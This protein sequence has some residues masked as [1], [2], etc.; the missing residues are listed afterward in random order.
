MDISA[1]YTCFAACGEVTTDSRRCPAGSLFIA[2]RGASF[3]G[4]D[5]AIRALE[6]GCRYAVVDRDVPCEDTAMQAR[7]LRVDDSLKALQMLARE[8]RRR[9][10]TR[11]IG[12]TGT[13]GKTTTKEL[14]AAVLQRRFHVLYTQG[15]LNNHIG[16]PL[17]LLRLTPQHELA[18]IEMG[19]SHPGDI[20][21]LTEIAE[22]DYGVIT[23]VGRAHL[24]GFGS[25]EGVL[26]TKGEL[27]DWLREHDGQG[28]F[29]DRDNALLTGIAHGL[30]CINYGQAPADG[31]SAEA[32]L[33]VSG[34]LHS[35][36]PFLSF[37][38][39]H[40]GQL[41]GV[42]THLI[43]S[44]NL[45]NALA[46]IAAGL[47]FGVPAEEIC[48]ALSAYV[49]HNN[50]SQLTLTADN[51]LIVDAYNAN[52]T[53]MMAAL[54]NFRLMEVPRKMAILGDMRELGEC[55]EE[56]HRRVAD[57]LDECKFDRVILVGEEFARV[58]MHFEHY[59]DVEALKAALQQEKP[60][61]WHILIKGSNGIRLWQLPE[62]L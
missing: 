58:T 24:Q 14:M 50:R 33:Y 13:N 41:F 46:A 7:L 62:V 39:E 4:N 27:Y 20:R 60:K 26:R 29:L 3:D 44:Y 49:P 17:T 40:D 59:R 36:A 19:A 23:N 43:G 12:I 6:Q 55:S 1:L 32:G 8:H 61:G 53:S 2:L 18:V 38:W 28:I 42:D 35:C 16:V 25:I 30:K 47:Y 48:E 45:K 9:L 22:P 31:K 5:F 57:Y 15:N 21:E 52:P 56:E 54:E 37:K 34:H 11:I 51:K 10:G